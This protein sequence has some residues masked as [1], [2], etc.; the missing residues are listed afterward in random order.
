[1]DTLWMDK[2]F[3]SPMGVPNI[4]IKLL[5]LSA[6][7]MD[8]AGG[9]GGHKKKKKRA[10]G[11]KVTFSG[12]GKSQDRAAGGRGPPRLPETNWALGEMLSFAVSCISLDL[13]QWCLNLRHQ[14]G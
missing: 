9:G 3:S 7:S 11:K 5:Y 12:T 8:L 2:V 6:G 4:F 1:M 14:S 10:L 13:V